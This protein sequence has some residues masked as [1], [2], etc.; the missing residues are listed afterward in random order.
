ML[1]TEGI[2]P[3]ATLSPPLAVKP[4]A[5]VK[6][7]ADAKLKDAAREMEATFLALLLK[8]MRET[9]EPDGGL[10]PGDTGD[11][12]GGLFDLFMSK[13]LADAGGVGV[14]TALL[15]QMQATV[16]KTAPTDAPTPPARGYVAPTPRT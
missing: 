15:R 10:F 12:Q 2:S 1:T 14:A 13:H 5:T 4:G 8:Q 11:V 16:P 6:G 3:T 7:V 9:L